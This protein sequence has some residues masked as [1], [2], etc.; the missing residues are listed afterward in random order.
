[1]AYF[2]QINGADSVT[3]EHNT[4][5]QA[6]NIISSYGARTGHFVFRDNIVQFNL[7]GVVCFTP[8][9]QCA[10]ENP[11][12]NC[13][14]EGVFRGNVIADNAGAVA[15]EAIDRKYP[16]G[17]FFSASF[18]TVGFVDY[19]RGNWRLA[20]NSIY[21]GKATDGKDPGVNFDALSAAGAEK[22]RGG[23]Q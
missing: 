7:Y 9:I 3:V 2:L 10:R 23:V 20:A 18:D 16:A 15:R 8:G 14:P 5:Q 12:C 13:F 6:G 19:R 17:N 22:A 4:V 1:M 21:R 11:F